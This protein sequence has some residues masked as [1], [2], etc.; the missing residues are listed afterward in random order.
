MSQI[1]KRNNSSVTILALA[2]LSKRTVK[3]YIYS[4]NCFEQFIA[5]NIEEATELD[6]EA[7]IED[8]EKKGY[9]NNTINSRI[10]SLRSIFNWYVKDGKMSTNPMV[11]LTMK[12]KATGKGLRRKE[13][14]QRKIIITDND[15]QKIIRIENKSTI[16]IETLAGTGMRISELIG[17]KLYD[18]E[19]I[20]AG[21]VTI[22]ILGKGNKYRYIDLPEEFYQKILK[23][24]GGK[25]YLF[26]SEGGNM[27]DSTNCYKMIRAAFNKIG[28][29]KV[30]CH[31][32]RHYFITNRIQ[33]KMPLKAVSNFVGHSDVKTTMRYYD[34][35]CLELEDRFIKIA[36]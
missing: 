25:E 34:H 6:I 31:S 21:W 19:V 20:N 11:D 3:L 29:D 23:I 16:L 7:Y 15:L 35:S 28:I 26:E 18:S 24:Y 32:L 12:L 9:K 2:N 30:G 33:K 10:Y 14:I 36:A 8:L 1:I 17:I 27:L 22:R 5:K 13:D 4:K